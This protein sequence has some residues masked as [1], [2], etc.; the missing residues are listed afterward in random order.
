VSERPFHTLTHAIFW[1]KAAI[2]PRQL[3][4]SNYCGNLSIGIAAET[5]PIVGLSYSNASTSTATIT[6]AL[7]IE[8]HAAPLGGARSPSGSPTLLLLLFLL[9]ISAFCMRR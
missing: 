8:E 1:P 2:S 7:Q 4:T 9:V 3:S 6:C 5:I